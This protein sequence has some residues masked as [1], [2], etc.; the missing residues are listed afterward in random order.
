MTVYGKI[1]PFLCLDG[2]KEDVMNCKKC[3]E[4]LEEE[5]TVCPVCGESCEEAET[6]EEMAAEA[7]ETVTETEELTEEATDGVSFEVVSEEGTEV[8][9]ESEA[10][11]PANPKRKKL[12]RVLAI[13][14]CVSLALALGLGIW[15]GVNGGLKPRE[16]NI[17][18]L[19]DYYAEGA[20]LT[21]AMDTVIATCGDAKLTNAVLQPL[22]WNQ[23][24][25]FLNE[26]SSY[27]PYIGIDLSVSFAEQ[28]VSEGG[29]TYQQQFL[30]SALND[31][32]SYQVLAQL[33]RE[34]GFTLSEA[35]QEQIANFPKTMEENA[36]LYSLGSADELI[37]KEMGAGASVEGYV[38]YM[39]LYFYAMEYFDS[40]YLAINPTD[41]EI[42]AY[43]DANAEAIGV[44]KEDGKVVD[45][46][47]IL[48]VPK[49]GTQDEQGQTTYS[50]DEWEACRKAAEEILNQWKAG[51]ADEAYFA[52][53]ATEK[54]ED[55][56]SQATGGLYTNVYEGQMVPEFNDWC[57][58]DSRQTGDTGLVRTSYG[59]H[60]MYFVDGAETWYRATKQSIASEECS[61]I[62]HDAL[63]KSPM[64]VEYK[65]IRL[66]NV[67][68]G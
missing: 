35:S 19:D 45:V 32:H 21:G 60:V 5:V 16:N 52:Q 1:S 43:Y 47:H 4:L 44:S 48:V 54:T 25:R 11:A 10:P 38:E 67:S 59:Y 22:Y 24:Y 37:Q 17:Q 9:A 23:T 7:A 14:C 28:Y 53:L 65:K 56:G 8:L 41:E 51:T 20:K 29:P 2:R 62:L 46:R 55:P 68:L 61:K 15:C 3:G 58:D 27:L 42:E 40:V 39:E 18:R 57:F 26:Y 50:E 33:G 6:V 36:V 31:W 63:E 64:E 12:L 66:G 13:V 30:E 34:A 49:G